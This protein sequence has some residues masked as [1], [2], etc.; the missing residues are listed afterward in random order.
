VLPDD[1]EEA[2]AARVLEQEHLLYPR[3]LKALADGLT[4]G[5]TPN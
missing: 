2:L 1:D 5:S 4:R 3:A